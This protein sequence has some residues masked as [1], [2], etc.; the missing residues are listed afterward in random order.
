MN[1]PY[2]PDANGVLKTLIQRRPA[3]TLDELRTAHP[4]LRRMSLDQLSLRLETIMAD[5]A[6]SRSR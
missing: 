1:Y 6:P 4:M 2:V 5:R 3:A